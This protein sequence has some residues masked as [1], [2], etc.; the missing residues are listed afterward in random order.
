MKFLKHFSPF[1]IILCSVWAMGQEVVVIDEVSGL[2]LEGVA[3][4]NETKTTST[5]SNEE[6]I[7]NLSLFTDGETVYVQFYGFEIRS[8]KHIFLN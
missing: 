3:L 6:G 1:L 7:A 2:P 8:K 5:L 4:Y